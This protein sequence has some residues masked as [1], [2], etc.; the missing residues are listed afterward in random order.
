[1]LSVVTGGAGNI[2][3]QTAAGFKPAY[4]KFVNDVQFAFSLL[5]FQDKNHL[6]IQFIESDTGAV[7]D[8]STLYK[9]HTT[10][11]VVQA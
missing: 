4:I 3:G 11:F 6:Q 10:Q 2:E 8:T 1:M 7:L 9:A 5:K